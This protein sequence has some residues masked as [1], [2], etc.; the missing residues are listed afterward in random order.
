MWWRDFDLCVSET[1]RK[2]EQA[3]NLDTNISQCIEMI[4]LYDIA[5]AA[6]YTTNKETKYCERTLDHHNYYHI[7]MNK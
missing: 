1:E 3:R 6:E 4:E 7:T 5:I 2:C